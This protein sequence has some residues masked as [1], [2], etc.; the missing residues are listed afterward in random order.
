MP[1]LIYVWAG[2]TVHV[3]LLQVKLVKLLLLPAVTVS[4]L[5]QQAS[6]LL[7]DCGVGGLLSALLLATSSTPQLADC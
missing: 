5:E 3:W 6:L 2:H 7:L 4:G 1:L